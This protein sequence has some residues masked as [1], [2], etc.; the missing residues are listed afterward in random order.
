VQ[1]LSGIAPGDTV[2]VSDM[3]AYPDQNVLRL[4]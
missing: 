2:I 4:R 1:V 3:S